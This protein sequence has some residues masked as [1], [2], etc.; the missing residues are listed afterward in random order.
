[1]VTHCWSSE[2]VRTAVDSN[3]TTESH[4]EFLHTM[5]LLC[6]GNQLLSDG[7][8]HIGSSC[9]TVEGLREALQFNVR[10]TVA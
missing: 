1:M 7:D 2:A 5:I 4:T 6:A 9:K 3:S 10:R 8:K